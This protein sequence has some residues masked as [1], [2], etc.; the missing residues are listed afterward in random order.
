MNFVFNA[1]GDYPLFLAFKFPKFGIWGFS[2]TA[3]F[4]SICV[5]FG[6]LSRLNFAISI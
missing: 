4:N 6:T 3:S 5:D 2:L 1:K